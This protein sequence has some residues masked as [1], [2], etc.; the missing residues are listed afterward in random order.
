MIKSLLLRL[1][2]G[3]LQELRVEFALMVLIRN[4]HRLLDIGFDV[5]H[6]VIELAPQHRGLCEVQLIQELCN[7]HYFIVSDVLRHQ[8]SHK[9]F[10]EF[11]IGLVQSIYIFCERIQALSYKRRV[12]TV[13]K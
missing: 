12:D 13:L 9:L 4:D 7:F 5:L 8:L 3:S 10:I 2:G 11:L 1:R 6:F